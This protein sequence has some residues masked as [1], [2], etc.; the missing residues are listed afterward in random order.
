LPIV[1]GLFAE[2]TLMELST[3]RVFLAVAGERSFSAAARKLYRTQPAVSLSVRRLE[4]ELGEKLF[5]RSSKLATLT[6]AGHLLLE[7]AQ[8]F[9]NLEQETRAAIRE[10]RELERGRVRIGANET[11][12]LYLLPVIARYRSLYPQVKVEVVRS[13]S[14][15]VP[16]ELLKRNLDLGI[17]S[18]EPAQPQLSS[19][20]VREDR[21]SF[22]V[23]PAH[24]FAHRGRISIRELGHEVFAAHN[25]PSPY[26]QRVLDTFEKYKV[27]LHMDVEL[28]TVEAIKKFVQMKAAVALVPRMC[29]ESE[30]AAGSVVELPVPELHIRRKIRLVYRRG[31]PLSHAARAFLKIS[32]AHERKRPAPHFP[33][34]PPGPARRPHLRESP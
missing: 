14:R 8:R 25:V 23:H 10:L 5:N 26:R 21:L 4:D 9:M 32:E 27:P 15:Q 6:D 22:I 11:G 29:L 34:R 31:D 20:V 28:P 2:V 3:L 33:A 7:Y 13:L 12:A 19:I 24:R 17:L 16:E 30:L 1:G 18:Y